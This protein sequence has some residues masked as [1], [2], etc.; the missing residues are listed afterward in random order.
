MQSRDAAATYAT[1]AATLRSRK[2][3]KTTK[4]G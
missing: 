4:R 1:V 2:S 3:A